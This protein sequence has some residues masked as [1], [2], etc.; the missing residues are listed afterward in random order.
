MAT[1]S[2]RDGST[3][4]HADPHCAAHAPDACDGEEWALRRIQQTDV[5]AVKALFCKLHAFNSALDPRFALA[6]HWETHFHA[7]IQQAL[8]GDESLGLIARATGTDQPCGFALAAVHRDAGMWRY[9]EW[10]EVQAMYVEDAWRGRGL[11]ETLLACACEWAE[12]V[13]QS[14]LQLYVTASNARAIHFY[15]RHGFRETQAILRKVLA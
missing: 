8:C 4:M 7:A 2:E 6:E 13:G 3:T 14:V 11:A 10:V 1:I 15:R 12:S 9:H 5:L